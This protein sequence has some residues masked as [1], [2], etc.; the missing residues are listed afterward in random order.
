MATRQPRADVLNLAT[1]RSIGK[2]LPTWRGL[3]HDACGMA[4]DFWTSSGR[5]RYK[6][7][8]LFMMRQSAFFH[9]G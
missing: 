5:W 9:E 3:F 8:F 6:A 7:P 4:A 1:M 2:A